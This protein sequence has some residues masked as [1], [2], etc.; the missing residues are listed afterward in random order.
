MWQRTVRKPRL[1]MVTVGAKLLRED[2][3]WRAWVLRQITVIG[4]NYREQLEVVV[5]ISILA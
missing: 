4:G 5:I 2:G 3:E 1:V